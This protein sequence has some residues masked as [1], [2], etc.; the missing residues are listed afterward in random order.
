MRWKCLVGLWQ[1]AQ[2]H[3]VQL[4]IWLVCWNMITSLIGM[5]TPTASR[6]ASLMWM[7]WMPSYALVFGVY[8]QWVQQADFTRLLYIPYVI[9]LI[10]SC[11]ILFLE[12]QATEARIDFSSIFIEILAPIF[13]GVCWFIQQRI[14]Q[15]LSFSPRLIKIMGWFISLITVLVMCDWLLVL[16]KL[17]IQNHL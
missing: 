8:N 1:G 5:E 10:M 3:T 12:I 14:R 7:C 4:A 15:C 13:G 16:Y 17:L 6:C 11:L 9:Y 2:F